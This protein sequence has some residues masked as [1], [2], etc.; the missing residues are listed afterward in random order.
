LMSGAALLALLLHVTGEPVQFVDALAMMLLGLGAMMKLSY[1]KFISTTKSEST[2]ESATG[3]GKFGE[4]SLLDGPHSQ[5]NYLLQEMG[6]VIARKHAKVLRKIALLAGF[7]I[8]ALLFAATII[9]FA[10]SP[11]GLVAVSIAIG[12]MVIGLYA[13]RWLFFAEAKHAV[14]LYYGRN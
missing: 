10:T 9:Y 7:I 13:E 8:P 3:L 4:V 1:W 5:S 12:V 11:M 2:I 6:F 14:T